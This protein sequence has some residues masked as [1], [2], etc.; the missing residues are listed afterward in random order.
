MKQLPELASLPERPTLLPTRWRG[1][2]PCT[3]RRGAQAPIATSD[4]D[5]GGGH[6]RL[7][8]QSQPAMYASCA[9]LPYSGGGIPVPLTDAPLGV[10][11]RRFVPHFTSRGFEREGH[12][13]RPWCASPPPTRDSDWR[14][15]ICREPMI[16][17]DRTGCESG[18]TVDAVDSKSTA[19]RRG[20]SNPPSRTTAQVPR[21]ARAITLRSPV[22]SDAV[23]SWYCGTPVLVQ[24]FG[25]GPPWG[26]VS[27]RGR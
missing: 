4:A 6:A 5:R 14:F 15:W 22:T 23:C 11:V 25:M 18:G 7:I 10:S 19:A 1:L 17:Y 16:L 27:T 13:S 12:C 3:T 26:P 20:G 21:G 24:P 9:R 8:R 2:S